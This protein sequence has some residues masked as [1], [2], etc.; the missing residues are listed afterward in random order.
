MKNRL[1]VTLF[2]FFC[3]IP[4]TA[5]Y[6]SALPDYQYQF[7]RD[8][9]NHPDYQTEWWYY[10]GNL[11][12]TDGHR[13]GFELTFFR[14]AIHRR[15][16]KSSDWEISDLYLAHLALSDLDSGKFYH[17]E[18]LNREGPGLA[19]INNQ[20]ATVWNGNWRVQWNGRQQELFALSDNFSLQLRLNTQKPPVIHGKNGISQKAAGLG[21]ASHYISYT[22]LLADGSL[23]LNGK[24]YRV[25]GS[26]WMDHEFFTNSLAANQVGWDWISLQLAD[27]TEIM[28]Y[29]FR[30]KDG[31]IDPFSS[32]TYIDAQ[33]NSR[34]LSIGD[35]TMTPQGQTWTSDA[36]HATYP[37][38]WHVSIPSMDL[39]LQVTT[40]LRSQELA[41]GSSVSPNYWEGAVVLNGT[42]NNSPLSGVG[43][44]EMT[45]YSSPFVLGAK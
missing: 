44:L 33:G 1:F 19:G 43:Y 9:F 20:L 40:P 34:H 29:R 38:E 35:F 41:G 13:F 32:G 25:E 15:D 22:R 17:T 5:Q 4:L 27:N 11:R 12:A 7:P 3:A 37:I 42:R 2:L 14:Q 36:T 39:H 24:G 23:Q 8:N 30:R 6:Q 21:R 16:T 26:T 31:S 45:G 10:T 18:R 28:L